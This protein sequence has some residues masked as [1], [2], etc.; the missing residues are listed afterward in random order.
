MDAKER[1]R[2]IAGRSTGADIGVWHAKAQRVAD[3]RATFGKRV[4]VA[5]IDGAEKGRLLMREAQ[6]LPCHHVD[7]DE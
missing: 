5:A 4:V 3:L 6:S 1:D 2:M 7:G